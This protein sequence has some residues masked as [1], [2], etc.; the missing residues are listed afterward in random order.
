MQLV[1]LTQGGEVVRMSKRTGK[2][3]TL[4]D[5]LDEISVDAARFFFNSRRR[6]PTWSSIW[7]WPCGR[8]ATTRS[9]TSSTPTP[10]SAAC[11]APWPRTGWRCCRRSRSTFSV[12]EHEEEINLIKALSRLPEEIRLGARDRDPSVLNKYAVSLAAQFHRFYNNCRIRE[13]ESAVRQA[14][15]A[16]CAATQQTIANVLTIIGVHAPENM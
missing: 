15:L 9:I 14:R 2:S 6:P 1:R 8:T 13:A 4:S 16:L 5:L 10:G 11:C 12:L 7:T 3:I